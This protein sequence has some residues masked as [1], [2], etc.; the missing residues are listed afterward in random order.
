MS[1]CPICKHPL[2]FSHFLRNIIS[3]INVFILCVNSTKLSFVCICIKFDFS[4]FNTSFFL[5]SSLVARVHIINCGEV[6]CSGFEPWSL[7]TTCNISTN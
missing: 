1:L 3:T 7:H 4:Y 6:E 2:H 5:S